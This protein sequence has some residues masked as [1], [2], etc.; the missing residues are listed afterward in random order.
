MKKFLC[1]KYPNFKFIP[2]IDK[3]GYIIEYMDRKIYID[4]INYYP[5]GHY[6]D[7]IYC[8]GE[9][10]EDTYRDFIVDVPVEKLTEK[11]KEKQRKPF[12]VLLEEL[13][14]SSPN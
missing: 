10:P 9:D 7:E 4:D 13:K 3:P 6:G 5:I 1:D 8:R 2:C 11:D 14:N 12:I